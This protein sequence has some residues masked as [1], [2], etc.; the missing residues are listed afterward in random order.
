MSTFSSVRMS[1][2][3]QT[4]S[5]PKNILICSP[6]LVQN[7][8]NP[9]RSS[10]NTLIRRGAQSLPTDTVTG[11]A[12][13]SLPVTSPTSLGR[14]SNTQWCGTAMTRPPPVHSNRS[15]AL[16][17]RRSWRSIVSSLFLAFRT[18]PTCKANVH[19]RRQYKK[20]GKQNG[21]N[22]N[23]YARGKSSSRA[24]RKSVALLFALHSLVPHNQFAPSFWHTP[25]NA[26][27]YQWLSVAAVCGPHPPAGMCRP[28]QLGKTPLRWL[29]KGKKIE[30]VVPSET[31]TECTSR[32]GVRRFVRIKT[33]GTHH[34]HGRPP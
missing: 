12:G 8:P 33:I 18:I 25:S 24:Q 19:T 27:G 11:L 17:S 13:S 26:T 5:L 2:S 16:Q 28:S 9:S 32:K 31:G 3:W 15:S 30:V 1:S 4:I 29:R 14:R 21:T 6:A 7:P 22:T 10:A 34:M 23:R 20:Q